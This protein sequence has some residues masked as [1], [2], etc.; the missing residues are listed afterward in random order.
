M[1]S[2]FIFIALLSLLIGF[3]NQGWIRLYHL[4]QAEKTLTHQNQLLADKNDLLRLE[5][6]RLK[7]PDYLRHYIRQE[8]GFLRSDEIVFELVDKQ[9]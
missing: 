1:K 2:L 3:A 4:L 5:I 8:I 6:N 9:P 7:D